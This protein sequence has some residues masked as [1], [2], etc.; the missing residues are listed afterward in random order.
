MPP[1]E[2]R[3]F[4]SPLLQA[5]LNRLFL[6]RPLPRF[7]PAQDR[8]PEE[9]TGCRTSAITAEHMAALMAAA[10][11]AENEPHVASAEAL[12]KRKVSKR[13]ETLN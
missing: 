6:S 1:R 10:K 12:K 4:A 8:E 13:S 2:L 11:D 9:R 5:P 7:I 3:D